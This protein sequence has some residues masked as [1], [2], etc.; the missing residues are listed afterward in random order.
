MVALPA[1]T[2]QSH[3]TTSTP[4]LVPT[5]GN[6]E[7]HVNSLNSIRHNFHNDAEWQQRALKRITLYSPEGICIPQVWHSLPR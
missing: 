3:L 4:R 2:P 6:H 7:G 5:E 1:W